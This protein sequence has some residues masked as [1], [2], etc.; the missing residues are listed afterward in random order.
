M[1]TFLS[2]PLDSCDA[3]TMTNPIVICVTVREEKRLGAGVGVTSPSSQESH[4][5]FLV[6]AI[7]GLKEILHITHIFPMTIQ[8]F[9]LKKKLICFTLCFGCLFVCFLPH[10]LKTMLR[11]KRKLLPFATLKQ[12]TKH[13]LRC[14]SRKESTG[15]LCLVKSHNQSGSFGK[16]VSKQMP[17]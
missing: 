16:T 10:H 1:F 13:H 14:V 9:P 11:E 3:I 12:H 17:D 2:P 6:K 8:I 7:T 5:W 4:V 15:N